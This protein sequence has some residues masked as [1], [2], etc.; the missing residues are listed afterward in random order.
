MG[1][2]S[3]LAP[4]FAAIAAADA[5]LTQI[6]AGMIAWNRAHPVDDLSPRSST[7]KMTATCS[8]TTN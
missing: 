8:A 7:P 4:A 6:A 2:G 1:S 5:E 3:M